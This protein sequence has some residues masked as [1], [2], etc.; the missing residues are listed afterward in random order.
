MGFRLLFRGENAGAFERDVDAELPMRQRGRVADRRYPDLL[1]VNDERI[2]L[3][4]DLAREAAVNGIEP[5]EMGVG[6]DRAEIV[7]GHDL[8]VLPSGLDDGAQYVAPDSPEAVDRHLD[9]HFPLLAPNSC[10]RAG[11]PSADIGI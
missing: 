11:R 2:A 10:H 1:T 5:Q 3:D 6:L 8:D 4:R 7:D 9:R